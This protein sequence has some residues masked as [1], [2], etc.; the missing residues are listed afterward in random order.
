MKKL[1]I[2]AA[3]LSSMA[4]S[5][6]AMAENVEVD[7]AEL[8]C[9]E[10]LADKEGITPSIFWLDGYMSAISETTVFSTD[11]LTA[12]TTHMVTYCSA[13]PNSTFMQAADAMPQE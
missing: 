6:P 5:A 3:L 12:L 10:F 1:L 9:A 8:T 4:V 7:M 13:N 11:W 2:A